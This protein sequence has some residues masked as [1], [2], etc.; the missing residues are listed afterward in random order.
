MGIVSSNTYRDFLI[1]YFHS[2]DSVSYLVE[3]LRRK[4]SLK[5]FLFF[6]CLFGNRVQN[7]QILSLTKKNKGGGEGAGQQNFPLIT[8][9]LQLFRGRK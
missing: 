1:K 6:F 5:K 8:K 7:K 2:K 4:A 3:P 9:S